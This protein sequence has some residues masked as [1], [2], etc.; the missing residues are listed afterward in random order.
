MKY[1]G[2]ITVYTHQLLQNQFQIHVSLNPS[3]SV[4]FTIISMVS[5]ERELDD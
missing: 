1:A 3:D 4:P 5:N 2:G